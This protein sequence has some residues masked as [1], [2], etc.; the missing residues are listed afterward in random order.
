MDCM[1]ASESLELVKSLR[2][3]WNPMESHDFLWNPAEI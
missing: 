2:P 1:G 3:S